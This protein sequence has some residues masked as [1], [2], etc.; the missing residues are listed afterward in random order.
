MVKPFSPRRQ[1]TAWLVLLAAAGVATA[2]LTAT[3]PPAQSPVSSSGLSSSAESARA[4]A[5]LAQLPESDVPIA[6]AVYSNSDRSPL[7]SQ[8]LSAVDASASTVEG[9]RPSGKPA[10]DT[11]AT[12][13]PDR[14]VA[15]V[16]LPLPVPN[17]DVAVTEAVSKLRKDLGNNLPSG[18]TVQVTGPAA[19]TADLSAVFDGADA[20]LL[21]TTL[22]VVAILLIITY[23]SPL[24]WLV[25]LTVVAATE[26]TS[27][28]LVAQVLP[29]VGIA[30]DAATTGIT[31]VLIFGAA[32][33]YA[34]LLIARYR[35][36]LRTTQDRFTAMAVAVRATAGA[37]TASAAT[38]TLT[39]ATLVLSAI[40]GTR[41]LG[42]SA[43]IGILVSLA[44]SLLVLPAALLVCGRRVFWPRVPTL[45]TTTAPSRYWLRLGDRIAAHP[46]LIAA[47]GTLTLLAF[48][49]PALAASTGLSQNEQFR[50]QPESIAGAKTL[51]AAFPAGLTDPVSIVTDNESGQAVL[52][53]VKATPGVADASITRS[54]PDLAQID[55]VLIAEPG[56]SQSYATIQDL[57]GAISAIPG[58]DA[59]V[60]GDTATRLDVADAQG[61]DRRLIIPLILAMVA[62]VLVLLLRSLLAPIVLVASVVL[63]YFASLG[64][65]W[66]IFTQ[67]LD[68]PALDVGVLLLSF[69]FLVALGVDYNIFLVTRAREETPDRGTRTAILTALAATGGVITSAGILLAAVFAVLG[70]LPLIVLTQI[71]VIVCVGVLLDTLLVRTIVVPA[72]VLILGDRFWWPHRP[73]QLHP[74]S[75]LTDDSRRQGNLEHPSADDPRPA[76]TR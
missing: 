20:T 72:A 15:F 45:G 1:L 42:L 52:Q 3:Q 58:A 67:L 12:V 57:R 41:A 50:V 76:A 18:V 35:D 29:R 75:P 14:T 5:R 69:V 36:Q 61:R 22:G 54:S 64:L 55:V 62:L 9:I 49:L 73:Q 33:D 8:Q 23:R 59:D 71:G 37:I 34:L 16:T 7:T 30:S 24:L 13:S 17:E 70:V 66:V 4:E 31:S 32:T 65:S 11:K 25:P 38:V 51:A 47:A 39:V 74:H 6:L 68:I 26:Q 28:A 19:L 63:S 40:E 10:E 48:T 53:V 2:V 21:F 43:A 46:R 27:L 56:S 44:A 60:G